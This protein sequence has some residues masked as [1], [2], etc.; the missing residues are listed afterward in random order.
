MTL[1]R[2]QHVA[3]INERIDFERRLDDACL[4]KEKAVNRVIDFLVL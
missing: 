4:E 2:F 1:F 3:K